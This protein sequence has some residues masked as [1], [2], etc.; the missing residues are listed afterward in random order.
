MGIR[1][2]LSLSK[3]IWSV[4]FKMLARYPRILLP[5]FITA[6]FEGLVLT[7]LF[8]YP[9]PPLTIIFAKPIR[10]FFGEHF[11][12]YPDNFLLLPQLFYYGQIFV[13][14]TVGVVMFGMAMGMV[15][16]ANTEGEE[17]K[18]FGSLN[19]ALRRY[20][21]L[22]GLWLVTFILSL[23]ILKVPRLLV[24]KFLQ[25][26]ASA[27]IFL[28][29][30]FYGSV[31]LTFIIEVLFIYAYPAIIIERRKFL[32]AIKKSFS[33]SKGVFLTTIVLVITPRI[34]DVLVMVLRQKFIGLM[35]L[36]L[37]E[38]TLVILA[39]GVAVTFITDSLV[40]LTTANLFVFSKETEKEVTT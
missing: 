8:Y 12:H 26:T 32:G 28:Q 20:I 31:V 5:F 29:V 2:A 11:L 37:P 25:P 16:Q 30:L 33:I 24:V 34:L 21:T 35:N 23:I 27:K 18:I 15:H 39:V 38:I 10:A 4:T 6:L 3:S 9:R 13:M 19:R 22:A 36:T 7:V 1:S 40:F 14:M 17:V